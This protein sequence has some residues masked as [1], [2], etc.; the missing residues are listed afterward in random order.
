MP[1]LSEF[2]NV[3][4]SALDLLEKKGFQLWFDEGS[5]LF[6]AERNGSDFAAENPISLLGLVAIFE[7][8]EPAQFHEYW[9]QRK[10]IEPRAQLPKVPVPYDSIM[11]SRR[12]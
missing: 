11:K 12:A 3:Y 8:E 9:W 6:F 10:E 1:T 5:E 4:D 2:P 7:A